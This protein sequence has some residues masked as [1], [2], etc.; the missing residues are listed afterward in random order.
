VR[1][2]AP[3]DSGNIIKRLAVIPEPI[4]AAPSVAEA[5]AHVTR[6]RELGGAPWARHSLVSW[7]ET[8]SFLGPRGEKDTVAPSL[9]AQTNTGEG[10]RALLLAGVGLGVLPEYLI[11]DDLAR[12]AL[13]KVCPGWV[14]KHVSLYAEMP[15]AKR[16]PRRV[17]L[18][19]AALKE[20]FSTPGD[21]GAAPSS[22]WA[23]WAR[24]SAG[25]PP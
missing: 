1:L 21:K 19:L 6:P 4:V 16:R 2:G 25:A 17:Q 15:S 7:G 23:R 5:F 3:R 24:A 12:G 14:W 20:A 9:R 10:L 22:G 18:F 13:V 11:A 8:M